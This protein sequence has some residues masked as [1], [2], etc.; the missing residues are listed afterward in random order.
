MRRSVRVLSGL[1]VLVALGG[2][3]GAA[4]SSAEKGGILTLATAVDI[5]SFAPADSRDAHYVQFYQPVY[6]SLIR[7]APDG[8]YQPM[9]ATA[10]QY[11]A[12][13]TDLHLTLRSGVSFTD[14]TPFDGNAV[15]ANLEAVARGTGTSAPA[16]ASIKDITVSDQTGVDLRLSRPDP[17]LIRQLGLP[18]GMMASPKVVGTDALKTTPVGTGPYTLDA[19][20]TTRTVQYTYVRNPKYWDAGA[21]PY[22]KIVLKPILDGTARLNAIRSGQVDGGIGDATTIATAKGA[23]LKV[24][25]SA[26][27]GFQG[28]FI[29]DRAGKIVPQLADVRVRQAINYA[30]DPKAILG[31]LSDGKGTLT[32]QVFNP[33]SNGW[34]DSLNGTYAYDPAKAKALLAQAGGGFTMSM[35]VPVYPNLQPLLTQQLAAVDIRINWVNVPNAQTNDQYLSGKFPVVW[36]QLQS[37]DPWQG[38]NF[39]GT[40]SAPWNP[41]HT[42]DPAIDQQIAAVQK[43]GAQPAE[44]HELAQLYID[45]AWFAPAYFPDAIYFTSAKV[46]ATPQALQIVPSIANYKPAK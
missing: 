29:F 32:G 18:G 37:S 34:D 40:K 45:K 35:P 16:F 36:Y 38:I 19:K 22:D 10:W 39:W 24:L 11:D 28:L 17:G 31:T 21:Y 27:P 13:R 2:C 44:L 41:L 5:N 7:I 12:A 33:K 43:S 1:L 26:G 20:A 9:L 46:D 25:Q 6:D 14:G 8:S 30:I 23:G 4:G 3:D 42:D 15:K